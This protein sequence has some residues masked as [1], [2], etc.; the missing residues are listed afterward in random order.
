VAGQAPVGHHKDFQATLE[1]MPDGVSGIGLYYHHGGYDLGDPA[2]PPLLNDS[3][4]REGVFA[5]YAQSRFRVAGA[6]LYGTDQVAT[7][8]AQRKI[9]GFYLQADGYTWRPAA[10]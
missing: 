9:H 2:A 6:Y 10:P 7:V 4:H 3:Y 1:A 5:N 8:T